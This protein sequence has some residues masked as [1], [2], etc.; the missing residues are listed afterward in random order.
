MLVFGKGGEK[1]VYYV[2]LHTH[3]NYSFD[4]EAEPCDVCA[5]ALSKGI[6]TIAL[7]DHYDVDCEDCGLKI[8]GDFVRRRTVIAELKER[9]K[10]KLD[11]IYGIELG[12]PYSKPEFSEDFVREGGYE[13]VLG[14]VHNLK[15]VP[16]FYY[17]DYTKTEQGMIE[18]LFSRMLDDVLKLAG[19]PYVHSIAH[20]T[21]PIRYSAMAKRTLEMKPFYPKFEAIFKEMIKTGKALEIN[22]SS[23]R[24]GL[25]FAMPDE[26][27]L[28]LYKECG[29]RY[30]T[31]GSDSHTVRDVGADIDYAYALMK[32][33]GF[34]DVTLFKGGE[35]TL[36]SIK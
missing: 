3:T 1:R 34:Y 35:K 11:I 36:I 25:G 22:T 12:Q 14:S 20:I 21:Y 9:F 4:G 33:C 6:G 15:N 18:N 26:E 31:V 13:F 28:S 16:D 19:V 24:K 10:G 5:S 8:E 17:I 29:G 7:T 2:D 30:I 23:V 32:K 27:I